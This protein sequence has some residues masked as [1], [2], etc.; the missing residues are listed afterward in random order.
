MQQ[1]GLLCTG[2][3]LSSYYNTVSWRDCFHSK[4]EGCHLTTAMGGLDAVKMQC[5]QDILMT[6][7]LSQ[8][9]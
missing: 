8:A 5:G 2:S 3:P 7:K 4:E 1:L 6:D 9:T